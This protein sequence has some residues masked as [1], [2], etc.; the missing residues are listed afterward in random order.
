MESTEVLEQKTAQLSQQSEQLLGQSKQARRKFC[1]KDLKVRPARA[2]QHYEREQP[3]TSADRVAHLWTVQM[4]IA[5]GL[6][7]GVIVVWIVS[8]LLPGSDDG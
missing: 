4:T 5:L 6:V 2:A 8:K 7:A 1:L 3:H